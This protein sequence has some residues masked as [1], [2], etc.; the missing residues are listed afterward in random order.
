LRCD[1]CIYYDKQ[2]NH[3][4]KLKN[5]TLRLIKEFWIK[6]IQECYKKKE[7]A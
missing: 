1:D 3:P 6:P 5:G 4:I 7:G 2:C